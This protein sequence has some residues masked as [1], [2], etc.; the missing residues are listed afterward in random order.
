MAHPKD[1][2]VY[3][4]GTVV[5][6][7]TGQFAIIKIQTFQMKGQGFLHYLGEIEGQEGLYCLIHDRLEVECL[8][9]TN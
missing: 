9:T 1:Y 8:P 5:R 4:V 3:P 6:L 7:K 2:E